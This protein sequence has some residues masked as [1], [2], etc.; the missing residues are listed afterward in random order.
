M[1]N[2]IITDKPRE[3]RLR[4]EAQ[5]QGLSLQKWLANGRY[6]LVASDNSTYVLGGYD[7]CDLDWVERRLNDLRDPDA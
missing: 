3:H 2:I 6:R 7:G 1:T 5:R 4:G